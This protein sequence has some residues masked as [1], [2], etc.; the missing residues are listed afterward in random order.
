MINRTEI[1]LKAKRSARRYL[2]LETAGTE[3]TIAA[4]R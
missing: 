2:G 1:L 3:A 4:K